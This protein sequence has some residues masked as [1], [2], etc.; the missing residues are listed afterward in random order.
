MLKDL[1][2]YDDRA[3]NKFSYLFN[4]VVHTGRE[5]I[6]NCTYSNSFRRAADSTVS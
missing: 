1:L 3:L 6:E 5:N 4:C 2:L